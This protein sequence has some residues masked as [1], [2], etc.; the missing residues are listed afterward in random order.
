MGR[1]KWQRAGYLVNN[2]GIYPFKNFLEVDE[3]FLRKVVS[4]NLDA[5]SGY[6]RR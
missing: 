5:A 4:I 6:V 3:G 2:A 1:I